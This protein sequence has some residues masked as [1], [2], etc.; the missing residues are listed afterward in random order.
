MGGCFVGGRKEGGSVRGHG[1]A[2]RPAH[3]RTH[4][5]AYTRTSTR[6]PRCGWLMSG[7]RM[8]SGIICVARRGVV[9]RREWGG[10]VGPCVCPCVGG[11]GGLGKGPTRGAHNPKA[12]HRQNRAALQWR[13]GQACPPIVRAP[14]H[15]PAKPLLH[16]AI[17]AALCPPPLPPRPPPHAPT[18]CTPFASCHTHLQQLVEVI[19][20]KHRPLLLLKDLC[21]QAQAR[22]VGKM[23]ELWGRVAGGW[24]C[25][26]TIHTA[27]CTASRPGQP[28]SVDVLPTPPAPTAAGALAPWYRHSSSARRARAPVARRQHGAGG[29]GHKSARAARLHAGRKARLRKGEPHSACSHCQSTL[30]AGAPKS[31]ACTFASDTPAPQSLARKCRRR[32]SLLLSPLARS[33]RVV[34]L[35][36]VRERP[37]S[38]QARRAALPARTAPSGQ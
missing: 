23:R 34:W 35:A 20:H 2:C 33:V 14:H 13:K 8:S 17:L 1:D 29:V 27:P 18:R 38:A 10:E 37:R 3:A 19:A 30:A 16:P 12:K 28:P 31:H 26:G 25:P 7:A 11:A 6:L 22:E 15:T 9:R 4:A 32:S 24:S 5:R 36:R 21:N